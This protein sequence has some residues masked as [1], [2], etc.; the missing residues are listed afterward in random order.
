MLIWGG[1]SV[2]SDPGTG[3]ATTF[4]DGASYAIRPTW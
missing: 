3:N 4:V 1:K 2:Q